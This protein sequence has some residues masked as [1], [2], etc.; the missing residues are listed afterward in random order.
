MY[1]LLAGLRKLPPTI[2][3]RDQLSRQFCSRRSI[4]DFRRLLSGHPAFAHDQNGCSANCPDPRPAHMIRAAASNSGRGSRPFCN[5][6]GLRGHPRLAASSSSPADVLDELRPSGVSSG[7]PA[8]ACRVQ[9]RVGIANKTQHAAAEP[10]RC[11]AV[12]PF[13]RMWKALSNSSRC[14]GPGRPDSGLPGSHTPEADVRSTLTQGAYPA[15]SSRATLA[16]V[17]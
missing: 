1:D 10:G 7:V 14:S 6:L 2:S 16:A 12:R 11:R 17:S 13:R 5:D 8:A 3:D 15:G 4:S 9:Y